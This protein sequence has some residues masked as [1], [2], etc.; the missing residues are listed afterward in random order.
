MVKVYEVG[1]PDILITISLDPRKHRMILNGAVISISN[2]Y[3][4][5]HS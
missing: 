2:Y 4:D 3:E 5:Y 1:D